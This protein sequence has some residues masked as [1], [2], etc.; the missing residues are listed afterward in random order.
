VDFSPNNDDTPL[1]EYMFGGGFCVFIDRVTGKVL[2]S[3]VK[4]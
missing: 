4:K 3:M 1:G 2:H